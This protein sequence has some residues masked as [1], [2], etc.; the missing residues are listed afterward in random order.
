WAPIYVAASY[1][2]HPVLGHVVLSGCVVLVGLALTTE[3]A[4][5]ASHAGATAMALR[6]QR[7]VDAALRAAEAVD[8]MGL[9]PAVRARWADWARQ[10]AALHLVSGDRA[11][12]LHAVSKAV[13]LTLQ[14]MA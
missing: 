5:R 7:G 10:A 11:A 9:L 6:A 13:R 1:L 2:L 4:T 14:I 8:A 12:V 3:L